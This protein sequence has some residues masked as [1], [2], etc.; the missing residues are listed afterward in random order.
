VLEAEAGVKPARAARPFGLRGMILGID[1]LAQEQKAG[2]V[3]RRAATR[4]RARDKGDIESRPQSRIKFFNGFRE[5]R[6]RARA[7]YCR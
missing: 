1:V 3:A 2:R 5:A 6:G 7:S 4:A